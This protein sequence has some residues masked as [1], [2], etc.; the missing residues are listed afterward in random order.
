MSKGRFPKTI[1]RMKERKKFTRTRNEWRRR[2]ES[3]KTGGL[4]F[5]CLIAKEK[6]KKKLKNSD[7]AAAAEMR[8]Y[9][10][11]GLMSRQPRDAVGPGNIHTE[12][13]VTAAL[14]PWAKRYDAFVSGDLLGFPKLS[15][16]RLGVTRSCIVHGRYG[17]RTAVL[18]E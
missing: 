18:K 2:E 7:V 10:E 3:N 6:I 13:G 11:Q 16:P 8:K 1:T 4:L 12:N 5:S 17:Q 9:K 14:C 15:H